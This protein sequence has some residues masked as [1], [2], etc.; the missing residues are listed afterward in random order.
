MTFYGENIHAQGLKDVAALLTHVQKTQPNWELVMDG[1]DLCKQIKV[2]SPT[3]NVIH[4][5]Y[6][7]TNGDD[8]VFKRYSPQQWL[9]AHAN[10]IAAGG[11]L[12]TTCEP[13]WSQA[14]IDWHI[15]LMLLCVPQRIKL[16]VGNWS[17]GTPDP[18][19]IV[20]A[21]RLLEMLDEHRNIFV[22]GL[23][24]YANA[25]ITSGFVGGAPNGYDK[26]GLRVHPD[27]ILP[28]TWPVGSEAKALTKWH[29]GR[30][31]FWLDYCNSAKINPPRIVL[32]ETGFDDVNDIGW[33]TAGLPRTGQY[34]N[35][36]GF[37]TLQAYWTK[38]FSDWSE[39]RAYFE[40]LDYAE[41]NI[42]NDTPVEGG[43]LYCYGHIDPK[44]EPDDL[45]GH[46][47]FLSYLE[48]N[49][50]THTMTPNYTPASFVAG[51][52]YKISCPGTVRNIRETPGTGTG[53]FVGKIN[54]GV[55]VT[56]LEQEIKG[57]DYF[58]KIK[59]DT[60]LG[61]ISLDGN[62]VQMIRQPE[63]VVPPVIIPPP[64][65]PK[66]GYTPTP[67][68]IAAF[69]AFRV[70]LMTTQAANENK[71]AALT[72]ENRK[73]AER[74]TLVDSILATIKA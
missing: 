65:P 1:L 57:V 63:V 22:L 33:W 10:D 39:D 36:A 37:K 50:L 68:Q 11:W 7:A 60:I 5:N 55:L 51:A 14:V 62:R 6:A 2:A 52:K 49:A 74:L 34:T 47:E 56:A 30:F 19:H 9:D 61:W 70:D 28:H 45:E 42:F 8:D 53:A 69:E 35:I 40:Q 43:C 72:A 13:G 67:A 23:H 20:M 66:V 29:I 18:A 3:T 41:K 15:E 27:Y 16:V 48:A 58:W 54:D 21:N 73:L 26:D 32:T 44:W 12:H 25:V 38:I 17:V 59:S 4:R 71:I 31:Q 46:T 64:P 24:E